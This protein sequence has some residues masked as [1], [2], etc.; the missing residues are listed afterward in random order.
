MYKLYII[1]HLFEEKIYTCLNKK[2]G[3]FKIEKLE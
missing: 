3:D 2:D 1:I